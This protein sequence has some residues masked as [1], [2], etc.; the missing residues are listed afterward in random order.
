MPLAEG[1]CFSAGCQRLSSCPCYVPSKVKQL[2]LFV[3]HFWQDLT[4]GAQ[5]Y[6]CFFHTVP[7]DFFTIPI[8][9]LACNRGYHITYGLFWL[10]II[11]S[12]HVSNQ[13]LPQFTNEFVVMYSSLSEVRLHLLD[14]I[15]II[16]TVY[17]SGLEHSFP[18]STGQNST[19]SQ[20]GTIPHLH[21]GSCRQ[22]LPL[23]PMYL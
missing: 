10:M 8:C 23:Y 21:V 12:I 18:C 2:L 5:M 15:L 13:G 20:F 1:P 17:S 9:N 11:Q 22:V 6:M 7:S 14:L 4:R 3:G 16:Q 19:I